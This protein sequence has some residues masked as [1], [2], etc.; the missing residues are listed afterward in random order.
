MATATLQRTKCARHWWKDQ[1][2]TLAEFL[3]LSEQK[4]ALE[5]EEGTVTQKVSPKAR[6]SR[7]QYEL[8]E[9][10]NRFALPRKLACA[11]P[12][13]RTT[14]GERSYVP[15]V[16]VFRWERIPRTPDGE[17]ADDVFIP[18]DIAVEVVSPKQSVN[19]LVRRCVQY[20][21]LGVDIALLVDPDDKSVISF[22]QGTNPVA[23]HGPARIE[24]DDVLPGFELTV[25]ELFASLRID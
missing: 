5:F 1:R 24:V 23:L 25:D 21:A 12:E 19:A 9:A 2:L 14:I 17:L 4:P 16:S 13:L 8:S 22:R 3:A 11:F 7:L 18:P 10:F 15:D 20:L 6:H